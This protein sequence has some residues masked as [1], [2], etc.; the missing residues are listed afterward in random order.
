M[1]DYQEFYFSN[2][3]FQPSTSH[4]YGHAVWTHGNKQLEGLGVLVLKVHGSYWFIEGFLR[5][6]YWMKS[7]RD[8]VNGNQKTEM[9]FQGTPNKS[10]E[11]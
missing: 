10:G 7:V 3:K 6:Y 2:I 4:P 8:S 11:V 1:R 5:Q 9:D